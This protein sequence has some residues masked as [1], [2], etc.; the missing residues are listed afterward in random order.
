MLENT[1]VI[2]TGAASGL[3]RATAMQLA[4]LGATVIVCDLGAQP[5]GTGADQDPV[6]AAAAE[7]RERGGEAMVSF[8]DVTDEGYIARTVEEAYEEYGRIDGAINYAGFLRDDMSFNMALEDWKAVLSV[9][10]DGH[11]N[12]VKHLGGHWRER[13]KADEIDRERAIVAISSASARGSASQINYST[14]KAGVLGLTRTAARELEQYDVRVNAVM[15]AAHTRML[16][17]NVPDEILADL[18]SD[19]LGPEKCAPLPALLVSDAAE[20]VTGWTFAIGGDTVY[21]L[22][23]PEFDRTATMDGGWTVEGLKQALDDLFD[24][25]PRAKTQ[26]GGLLGKILE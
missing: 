19:A 12:L 3:G 17:A 16:D 9:H 23:D 7:I 8:G 11:F 1:I 6:E 25:R 22:T 14:A 4:D 18:P 13:H 2:V 26:P 5:H 24:D 21:T 10:L 15:P 20:G